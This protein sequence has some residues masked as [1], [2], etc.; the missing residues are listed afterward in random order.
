M[1]AL[2]SLIAICIP[3]VAI[4]QTE[5]K[6][7]EIDPT[8]VNPS[9]PDSVATPQGLEISP[10][11]EPLSYIGTFSLM[12]N[13]MGFN[14]YSTAMSDSL[15]I[16]VYP[17]TP[18]MANIAA[19][20]NG[21]LFAT[22]SQRA[23]PGLMQI[24]HGAIGVSQNAGRFSFYAGMSANKYGYFQGLHTQY[25]VNGSATYTLNPQISFTLFGN[26]YF[27]GA[28]YM[29]NGM[30]MAPAMLGYYETN[31]FGGY[32]NYQATNRFG[33]L[34]GGQ[35]VQ[36]TGTNPY[37]NEPIVTPYVKVG[38]IGIGLPVGQILNGFLGR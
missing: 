2:L 31:T 25:G 10:I 5:V 16:P 38:K 7:V 20:K 8:Y 32:M 35:T 17:F 19:W 29:P 36:Q 14:M 30:P 26:Y 23:L 24:E 13:Y 27:G 15:V 11:A 4:A 28:P 18:G 33:V 21:R 9:L 1:K 34:V 37:R 22:G 6:S 12:P 3:F